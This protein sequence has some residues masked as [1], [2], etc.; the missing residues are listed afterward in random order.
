MTH[1]VASYARSAARAAHAVLSTQYKERSLLAAQRPEGTPTPDGDRNP[2]CPPPIAGEGGGQVRGGW[3]KKY[4]KIKALFVVAKLR[5][6]PPRVARG[7]HFLAER[8]GWLGPLAEG[9]GPGPGALEV[10]RQ[11]AEQCGAVQHAAK[12]QIAAVAE[13]APEYPGRVVMVPLQT[14]L[15]VRAAADLAARRHAPAGLGFERPGFIQLPPGV[16]AGLAY[17]AR[18]AIPSAAAPV[19]VGTGLFCTASGAGF[20]QGSW[21]ALHARALRW[22]VVRGGGTRLRSES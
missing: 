11:P 1:A 7:H 19:E 15:R 13:P 16:V 10:V 20:C 6:R 22:T 8:E 3:L 12:G 17:V 18:F 14:L 9:E 5:P 21:V 4:K 2:K